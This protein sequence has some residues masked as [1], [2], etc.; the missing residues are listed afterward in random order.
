[1]SRSLPKRPQGVMLQTREHF[2]SQQPGSRI[3]QPSAIIPGS[4]LWL[5]GLWQINPV[6]EGLLHQAISIAAGSFR[7]DVAH[8][9]KQGRQ[10]GRQARK[11]ALCS[12][13]T[14]CTCYLVLL[15]MMLNEV[16][17]GSFTMCSHSARAPSRAGTHDSRRLAA[18]HLL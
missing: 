13:A 16:P 8:L 9:Q 18:D 17:S 5:L 2:R 10:A 6:R 11:V 7:Q 14:T 12:G 4:K 1:M 15:P 3:T